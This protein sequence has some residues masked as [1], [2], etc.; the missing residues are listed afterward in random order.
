MEALNG[1]E[2]SLP[3]IALPEAGLLLPNGLSPASLE[4]TLIDDL[5]VALSRCAPGYVWKDE[6]NGC[7]IQISPRSQK[8]EWGYQKNIRLDECRR[9]RYDMEQQKGP[10][11]KWW[12]KN[13]GKT[14]APPEP[15]RPT[16]IKTTAYTDGWYGY[17]SNFGRNDPHW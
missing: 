7:V 5:E 11:R 14:T 12:D 6:A 17:G 9:I 2:L 4:Q 1:L 3:H 13:V 10:I 8:C 15:A 16:V